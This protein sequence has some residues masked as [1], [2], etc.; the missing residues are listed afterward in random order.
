MVSLTF[1]YFQ[2]EESIGERSTCIVTGLT[3][4][5]IAMVILIVD[6]SILETGLEK[7]YVS[8]NS[9]ASEFLE[10]QGLSSS[11][12][13][14]KIVVKFFIAC[15][16]GLLGA[17]FTFPGLR[18]A[19]MHWDSLKYCQGNKCM[20]I[21]LNVSFALPFLLVILWIKPVS[22]DYL[23]VRI[24][25]SM[26]APLLTVE[27]FETARLVAVILT[28][29]LRFALMPVYLQAYL[30]IAYQRVEE[31]KKE[32]GRIT[33]LELQKNIASIFYYLCVVTLQYVAPIIMCLYFVLMYKTLGEFTWRGLF[34]PS[35]VIEE[36]SADLEPVL[37][38]S[39]IET[40]D[41]GSILSSAQGFQLSLQSLKAVSA[42]YIYFFLT[43]KIEF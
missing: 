28:V 17:I 2:S 10:T 14:S 43:I 23:T 40:G 38:D 31:Q 16:C 27:A 8:F 4:L 15:S 24:F 35:S 22:R 39:G 12:P 1:Q 42:K 19:R 7:A 18:M 33:N 34:N 41:D 37:L 6:E 9:S 25:G 13:A 36:C 30:N 32:A 26:D 11:G 5:L 20:Q 21:L 3:Y 29:I